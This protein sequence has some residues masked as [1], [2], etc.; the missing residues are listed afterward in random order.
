MTGA[1]ENVLISS[2]SFKT[3]LANPKCSKCLKTEKLW[4]TNPFI[5]DDLFVFLHQLSIVLTIS[6]DFSGSLQGRIRGAS[7][8]KVSKFPSKYSTHRSSKLVP[9]M[10]SCLMGLSLTLMLFLWVA[11]ILQTASEISSAFGL[12]VYIW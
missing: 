4:R 1:S 12:W 7:V 10:I 6:L 9:S 2:L 5:L 3:S 8:A 11:R